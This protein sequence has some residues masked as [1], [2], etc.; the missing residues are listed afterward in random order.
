MGAKRAI[1]L[2]AR[3][4]ATV[5]FTHRERLERPL[6]RTPPCFAHTESDWSARPFG[7]HRFFLTTRTPGAP[8]RSG[9]TVVFAPRER[10]E[11]PL[12][13]APPCFSHHES[14][15]R[16][17]P[18]GR[19]RVVRTQRSIGLRIRSGATVFFTHRVRLERRPRLGPRPENLICKT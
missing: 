13:R 5:F 19:H 8:V 11:R 4:G 16:A 6:D 10:L 15:W 3:S 14:A 17:R 12:A 7:R 18:L 1:G 2:R 9:T